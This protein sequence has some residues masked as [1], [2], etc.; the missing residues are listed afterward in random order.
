MIDA[1]ALVIL[2][3]ACARLSWLF[4]R[5]EGP[6]E[7]LARAR[8]AM[9]VR[10]D[11]TSQPYGTSMLS[12]MILCYYCNSIWLGIIFTA[13]YVFTGS[14]VVWLSLPFAL[15]EAAVLLNNKN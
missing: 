12:K 5:E 6:Y 8:H 13:I 2:G 15:S 9:G 1:V 14:L 11:Q 10:Y 3:M 4:A 7:L